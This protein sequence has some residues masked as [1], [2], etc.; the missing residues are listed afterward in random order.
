MQAFIERIGIPAFIQVI[1]ELWNLVFMIIMILSIIVSMSKTD[2]DSESQK[3][4][5]PFS[6]EIIIFFF[7]IFMYNYFDVMCMIMIGERSRYGFFVRQA[8]ELGYF[9]VGSAQMIFFLRLVK[10]NI[11]DKI[12]SVKLVYIFMV[13]ILFRKNV[14]PFF[15]KIT[16]ASSIAPLLAFLFSFLFTDISFNNMSV[17]ITALIIFLLYEQNKTAISVN[18]AHELEKSKQELQENKIKLLV[19]QIQPHFIYNSI[20]ALQSKCTDDPE[21]YEGISSFGKYLR[22]NLTAMSENTL[23]PFKDELKHIKAYLQLEKLNFGD[24]L[25]VE[26]DI[27]IDDFMVPA[28]CVEPLVENAVRYGI[29]TYT[30][31]G[32]VKISVFDE[33]DYIMIEVW[34]DGSGGN[35]L[36]DVQKDRKSIGI[37]NVRLRLKAMDKGELSI[38]QDEKG[39]SAVIKL[40]PLEA[41]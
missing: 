22:A 32:L 20:M 27:E 4:Y 6:K 7:I 5:L 26:Y 40:K 36:T 29:S 38:T 8:A 37:E 30:D 9:A 21:L 14:D 33:P 24:K 39:T 35:K 13:F 18:N 25:R 16:L 11:A 10:K 23:I 28:F 12:G 41:V 3:L 1:I 31:G 17:S 2:Y 19:A 34:D 15:G